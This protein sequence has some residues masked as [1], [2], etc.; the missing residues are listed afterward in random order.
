MKKGLLIA[1]IAVIAVGAVLALTRTGPALPPKGFEPVAV[2]ELFTSEGCSSCPPADRLLTETLRKPAAGE[3]RVYGLSFH[4]DYWDRL[5]WK[6]PYSSRDYSNR[7][8]QYARQ[9]GARGL[10]TPQVVVNG[11]YELVGSNRKALDQRLSEVLTKPAVVKIT[12]RKPTVSGR[13]LAVAYTLEGDFRGGILQAALV[14]KTAESTVT[15][16]ENA[17]RRLSHGN[18]VRGLQSLPDPA[19]NGTLRFELPEGF[20]PSTGAVILF[21]QH[22]DLRVTGAAGVDL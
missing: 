2:V 21:A 6:D 12:L 20:D 1:G 19:P 13:T 22:P 9:L 17:G 18:V 4:V 11:A 14:S 8:R 16:G 10:Y 15:R 3:G 5:G 7:Q